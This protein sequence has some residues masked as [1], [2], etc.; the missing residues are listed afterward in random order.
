VQGRFGNAVHFNGVDQFLTIPP[1]QAIGQMTP[2]FTLSAWVKPV[3]LTGVQTVIQ[4]GPG[5]PNGT[6]GVTFGLSD[7]NLFMRFE[8]GGPS[9][10]Q[11]APSPIRLNEWNH[12]TVE[13]FFGDLYFSVNGVDVLGDSHTR[14]ASI[15]RRS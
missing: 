9:F 13:S 5:G 1:N 7:A 6:G 3:K 8:G 15:T 2:N 10:D 11:P 14:V 4:I 12:I